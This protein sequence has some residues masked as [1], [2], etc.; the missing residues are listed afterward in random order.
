MWRGITVKKMIWSMKNH[1][2]NDTM[3][4]DILAAQHDY[5]IEIDYESAG[6]RG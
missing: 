6:D 4:C 3:L 2:G 5:F 1:D